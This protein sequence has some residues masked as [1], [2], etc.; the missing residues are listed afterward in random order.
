M[1]AQGALE[2]LIIIAAVLGILALVVLFVLA[3]FSGSSGG[4]D[5]SKCRLAASACSNNMATGVSTTCRECETACKDSAGKEPVFDAVYACKAGKSRAISSETGLVF[6]WHFDEGSGSS[7]I[8]ASG[9]GYTGSMAGGIVYAPSRFGTALQFNG[10]NG[11]V[12][13]TNLNIPTTS[14]S[15]VTVEFW[16]NWSVLDGVMPMGFTAYDLYFASGCFGFNTA[17]GD[18]RG[19]SAVGLANKWVFVSAIFNSGDSR[20][21]ELYINGANQ[22]LSQCA[23]T[24]LTVYLYT[25]LTVGSWSNYGGGYWYQGMID[26]FRLYNRALMPQEIANHYLG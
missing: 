1:K 21:S 23:G 16:M 24:P 25:P 14:G 7:A 19:M 6:G 4:A 13:I 10:L 12:Q 2:Y 3:A 5:V 8:D 20:L 15:K 22:T 18:V 11:Y 17:H 9:N 26:E